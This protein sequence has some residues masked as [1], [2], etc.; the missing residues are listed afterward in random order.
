MVFKFI[1]LWKFEIAFET[2]TQIPGIY[3]SLKNKNSK[4]FKKASY[5]SF[6]IVVLFYLA[7]GVAGFL[8]FCGQVNL[9]RILW[10]N[11][12]VF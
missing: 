7:I 4:R 2:Q 5:L 1:W 9:G 8:G 10:V 3:K 11:K 6:F 12:D